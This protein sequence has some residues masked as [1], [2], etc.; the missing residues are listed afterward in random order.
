MVKL[1]SLFFITEKKWVQSAQQLKKMGRGNP[2]GKI[3]ARYIQ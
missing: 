2:S 3:N 1:F